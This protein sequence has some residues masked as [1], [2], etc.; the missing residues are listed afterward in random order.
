M[1]KYRPAVYAVSLAVAVGALI[2]APWSVEA[3]RAPG[4]RHKAGPADEADIVISNT[5]HLVDRNHDGQITREEFY[6]H[7]KDTSFKRLDA[8]NDQRISSA[9]WAAVETG[10]DSAALFAVWDVNADGFLSVTEFKET[11]QARATMSNLFDTLDTNGDG[12]L[13]LSEFDVKEAGR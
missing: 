7:V 3:Q 5:F 1:R 2:S 13:T 12:A 8:D 6:H 11:P 4:M 9:E 10:K